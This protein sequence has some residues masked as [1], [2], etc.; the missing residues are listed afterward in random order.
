MSRPSRPQA[1]A[2]QSPY[3]KR[4]EVAIQALCSALRQTVSSSWSKYLTRDKS[5]IE[6]IYAR[7]VQRMQNTAKQ[8]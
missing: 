1:R 8:H 7:S 3:E 5:E 6:H 4:V 2:A